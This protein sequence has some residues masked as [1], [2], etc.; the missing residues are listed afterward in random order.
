MEQA[1]PGASLRLGSYRSSTASFCHSCLVSF[2]S[3][4][5]RHLSVSSFSSTVIATFWVRCSDLECFD[6]SQGRAEVWAHLDQIRLLLRFRRGVATGDPFSGDWCLDVKASR[7][8][9]EICHPSSYAAPNFVLSC[10]Y[11]HFFAFSF[12]Y[13]AFYPLHLTGLY[14]QPLYWTILSLFHSQMLHQR[15]M[16]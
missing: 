13:L 15:L 8:F 12:S 6:Q 9:L 11:G 2:V 16:R 14:V 4:I 5:F 7:A 10:A 3:R 1:R